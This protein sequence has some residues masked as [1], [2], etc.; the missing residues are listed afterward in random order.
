[1]VRLPTPGSDAG[2]WGDILNYFL[3]QT[4][5]PDG[6]LKDDTVG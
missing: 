3:N 1:M 2:N 6:T 5:K 4:H